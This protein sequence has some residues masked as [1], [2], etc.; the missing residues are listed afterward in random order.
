MDEMDNWGKGFENG[1]CSSLNMLCIGCKKHVGVKFAIES[2]TLRL[3]LCVLIDFLPW[4]GCMSLV[5]TSPV[6]TV[7]C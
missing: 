2:C 1:H 7:I 5:H 4:C 3:K 6:K